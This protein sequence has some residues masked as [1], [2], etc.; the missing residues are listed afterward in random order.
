MQTGGATFT[1]T[2]P[3]LSTIRAQCLFPTEHSQVRR[4]KD[5]H[6]L[7][8]LPHRHKSS[9][10]DAVREHNN[11]RDRGHHYKLKVFSIVTD[12]SELLQQ[13]VKGN[14]EGRIPLGYPPP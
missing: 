6:T 1:L 11:R 14:Q 9:S 12:M 13:S 2:L 4:N 8:A 5:I 10:Q 7:S 3:L